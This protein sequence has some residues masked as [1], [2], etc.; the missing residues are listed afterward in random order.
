MSNSRTKRI[1]KAIFSFSTTLFVLLSIGY[2]S[3][4]R[5]IVF[6]IIANVIVFVNIVL[7]IILRANLYKRLALL[8]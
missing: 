7:F 5:R 3:S 4:D 1:V 2:L 6:A 8:R